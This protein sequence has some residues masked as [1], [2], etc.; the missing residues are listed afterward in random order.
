MMHLDA[1][2]QGYVKELSSDI[3]KRKKA[4]I[5]IQARQRDITTRYRTVLQQNKW[6]TQEASDSDIIVL[7]IGGTEMFARRDTLTIVEGSRL[8]TLFSGQWD[9]KLNRDALGRVFMEMNPDAFKKILEYLYVF[10]LSFTTNFQDN[11]ISTTGPALYP[12]INSNS[13]KEYFFRYMEFFG[14]KEH[15]RNKNPYPVMYHGTAK[16]D[17]MMKGLDAMEKRLAEDESFIKL[18]LIDHRS[19]TSGDGFT[20]PME[21]PIS[22]PPSSPL[23]V[24]C[25]SDDDS[26]SSGSFVDLTTSDINAPSITVPREADSEDLGILNLLVSGEIIVTKRSTLCLEPNSKLAQDFASDKW[27]HDHEVIT[28]EGKRCVLVEQPVSAFRKL[29]H[30]LQHQS[31]SLHGETLLPSL[32]LDY[33]R[34]DDRNIFKR[35]YTYYFPEGSNM[36]KI[37]DTSPYNNRRNHQQCL[38]GPYLHGSSVSWLNSTGYRSTLDLS[39]YYLPEYPLYDMPNQYID[40]PRYPCYTHPPGYPTDGI[41]YNNLNHCIYYSPVDPFASPPKQGLYSMD[42]I[43]L[44]N[45]LDFY[46]LE[47]LLV[48]ANRKT[49]TPKLLYRASVDGWH[50]SSFHRTCDNKG[51][52]LTLIKSTEGYIFGGFTDKSWPSSNQVVSSDNA[53]VFHLTCYAGVPAQKYGMKKDVYSGINNKTFA[54]QSNSSYGPSFGCTLG[55]PGEMYDLRIASNANRKESYCTGIGNPLSAYDWSDRDPLFLT[56]TCSFKVS[57]YEVFQV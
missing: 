44:H 3:S 52:T 20:T 25:S 17:Q 50:A 39:S 22:S 47:K 29:L 35:M 55:N 12:C 21:T 32:K 1:K 4:I 6:R 49:I 7:N 2:V 19:S 16:I 43:V 10:K 9:E 11:G 36:L 48:T 23:P 24:V 5:E 53:F 57:D 27:L 45:R 56:G 8:E 18:F 14:L 42:S 41:Q 40:Y 28:E 26:V 33:T 51:A 34:D 13:V 37:I 38:D 54:M 46:A 31:I 30:H 15:G